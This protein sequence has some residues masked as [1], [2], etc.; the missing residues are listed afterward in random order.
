[1]ELETQL[2][3]QSAMIAFI[4]INEDSDDD[5][6]YCI[7]SYTNGKFYGEQ[8]EKILKVLG[9]KLRKIWSIIINKDFYYS[10]VC[11]TK[12]DFK[13]FK[14]Y[15]NSVSINKLPENYTPPQD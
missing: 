5:D 7:M 6:M 14:A 15:I 1:M 10:E 2:N 13:K 11:M 12:E 3:V 9:K 4:R 8:D